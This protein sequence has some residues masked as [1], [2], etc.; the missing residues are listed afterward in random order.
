MRLAKRLQRCGVAPGSRESTH[1]K[2][3]CALWAASMLTFLFTEI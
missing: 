1:F 3:T 2:T